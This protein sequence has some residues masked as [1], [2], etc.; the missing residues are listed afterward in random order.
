MFRYGA[1]CSWKEAEAIPI[2]ALRPWIASLA[3][4]MTE[5]VGPAM[6]AT[7]VIASGARSEAIQTGDPM[8]ILDCFVAYGS[9]Q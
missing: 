5:P 4:A 2:G 8:K 9:S 3:L 6:S 7:P 1:N